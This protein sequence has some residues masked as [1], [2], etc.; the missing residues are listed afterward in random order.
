MEVTMKTFTFCIALSILCSWF[1]T[2][3]QNTNSREENQPLIFKV[4]SHEPNFKGYKSQYLNKVLSTK[5]FYKQKDQWRHIIDSMWG[6]GLQTAQK[7]QIFDDYASHLHDEFD[8]FQSLGMSWASWDSLQMYWRSKINDSTSQGIFSGIMSR[9][10]FSLRDLHTY[11]WDGMVVS[12]PL[13]SGVPIFCIGGQ[14]MDD[15]IFV[16]HFGGVLTALPD[17]NILV[18]RVVEHHPLNLQPGDIILGYEGVRWKDISQELLE[19]EI[20]IIG[21]NT[22]ASSAYN[23]EMLISSGMNW[24][25]FDTIDVIKYSTGDTLH[26]SLDVMVGFDAPP[27]MNAEQ[28][29]VPGINFPDW[30]KFQ[31][32]NYGTLEHT[33]IGYIYLYGESWT[34]GVHDS[35]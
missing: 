28:L 27:M 17:N 1:V 13:N 32:V 14:S 29:P 12:T 19:A 7:L 24:H 5:S 26:L 6:P 3:K 20:P 33:N 8:G 25:L 21:L 16:S 34:Y 22:N 10:A 35:P 2:A 30:T 18:L 11:A 31:V 9:F 15:S 4:K 23:D